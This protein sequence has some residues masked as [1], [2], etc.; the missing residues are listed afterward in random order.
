MQTVILNNGVE[1]PLL[2]FGTFQVT[3]AA[4]CTKSVLDAI[5]TGYRLIDTAA[6]YKNEEA[7]GDAIA[8]S[9]VA[10]KDL[11]VT[12]KL[13]GAD[14]TYDKAKKAFDT[15]LKKLKLDYLDLYLIH[16]PVNDVFGAWRAMEE[17]YKEGRVNAIGVCNFLPADMMNLVLHNEIVPALNQIET[18]VNY[19]RKKDH[20]F[21]KELNIQH[22]SWSPFGQGKTGV[23]ENET[24]LT[25]A[26]KY[27]RKPGQIILRWLLQQDIAVIPK[28]VRAERI[29]ENAQVFDFELLDED[30]Q[31]INTLDE[32]KSALFDQRDPEQIKRLSAG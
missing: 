3:D 10:R 24:I 28:S 23:F 30:M 31:L 1:M 15:S 29:A 22:Q 7:V 17:I 20:A 19:Q 5:N 11:F 4:E 27:N 8:T 16:W 6:F 2:G 32:G 21:L 9:G 14:T 18:H 26:A 13:W 25:I 12:T